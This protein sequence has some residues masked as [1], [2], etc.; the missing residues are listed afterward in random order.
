[1]RL[2]M[3]ACVS[4]LGALGL[5]AMGAPALAQ[6]Q[7]QA[8]PTLNGQI[9]SLG[10]PKTGQIA[11]QQIAVNKATMTYGICVQGR[12]PTSRPRART[13][14]SRARRRRPP[15]TPSRAS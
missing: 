8:C 6:P 11:V 9:M 12:R 10:T 2:P 1:M 13:R 5:V 3:R 14:P 4:V 15:S 7:N